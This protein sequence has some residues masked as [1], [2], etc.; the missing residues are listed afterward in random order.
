MHVASYAFS[1]YFSSRFYGA[2][3]HVSPSPGD[4]ILN[5]DDLASDSDPEY[6][7]FSLRAIQRKDF[8]ISESDSSDDD[9]ITSQTLQAPSTSKSNPKDPEK[10]GNLE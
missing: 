2:S 8:I 1:C 7:P 4:V 10:P 9:E 6:E 5:D 3:K